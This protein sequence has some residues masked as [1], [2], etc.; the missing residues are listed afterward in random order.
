MSNT[1]TAFSY[2]NK[3]NKLNRK[4]VNYDKI[5]LNKIVENSIKH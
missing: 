3:K 5:V 4:T 1:R 2:I